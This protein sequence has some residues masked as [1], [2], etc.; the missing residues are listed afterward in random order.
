M[1]IIEGDEETKRTVSFAALINLSESA[2]IRRLIAA[3]TLHADEPARPTGN[4][5]AIHA[6]YE[7]QRV[8]ARFI[9]GW[10]FWQLDDESGR[11]RSLPTIR[12]GITRTGRGSLQG[13]LITSD[14]WNSPEVDDAIARDFGLAP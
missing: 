3:S 1:A 7:G 13:R 6:D 10:D 9:D 8:R 12:P 11:R 4:G 14:D 2:I 5:T